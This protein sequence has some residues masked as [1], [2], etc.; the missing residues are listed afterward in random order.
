MWPIKLCSWERHF[1]LT[2]PLSI[3]VVLKC[4]VKF[5]LTQGLAFYSGGEMPLNA[6]K[7]MGGYDALHCET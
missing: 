3:Y 6:T 4:E 7:T 1:T 2:T 5:L